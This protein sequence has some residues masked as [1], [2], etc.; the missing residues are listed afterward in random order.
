[1]KVMKKI[2]E[3]MS[4]RI[5]KDLLKNHLNNTEVFEMV[6]AAYNRYCEDEKDGIDYIF[7]IYNQDDLK[8]LVKNGMSASEIAT[9]YE[10]AQ[11]RTSNYFFYD[12]NHMTNNV[13]GSFEEVLDLLIGMLDEVCECVMT[14]VTRCEEYQAI[15][16]RY[17]TD[18]YLE[19]KDAESL[20]DKTRFNWVCVEIGY[21][22]TEDIDALAALKRKLEEMG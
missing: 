21:N 2:I 3:S 4:K 19:Y 1:M 22:P 8:C 10:G 13:I 5:E 6:L 14:Y 17:V 7:D 15:Y 16:E 12:C 18:T 20:R 11:Y 9:I